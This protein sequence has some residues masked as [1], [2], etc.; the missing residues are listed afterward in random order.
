MRCRL[1]RGETL[2]FDVESH[3]SQ[4]FVIA[5]VVIIFIVPSSR[6]GTIVLVVF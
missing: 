5:V 2:L 4:S 3:V 1:S 6:S